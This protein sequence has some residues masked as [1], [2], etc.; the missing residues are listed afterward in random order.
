MKV[1]SL[2]LLDPHRA[3][4]THE[5]A[6]AAEVDVSTAQALLDE[7]ESDGIA[8]WAIFDDTT[9]WLASETRATETLR[10]AH[11][12]I[13]THTGLPFVGM[14]ELA[15]EAGLTASELHAQLERLERRGELSFSG[16]NIA[17]LPADARRYAY[18]TAG[19]ERVFLVRFRNRVGV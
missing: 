3:W 12:R 11:E 16:T 5:L 19:G 4:C 10:D 17:V 14:T 8:R 13:A 6:E 18:T 2:L 7:A 1:L 9:I 15:A